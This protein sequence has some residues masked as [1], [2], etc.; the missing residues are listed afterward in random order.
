MLLLPNE[1][2]TSTFLKNFIIIIIII[3]III[4]NNNNN[5]NIF[6]GNIDF[7]NWAHD[8]FSIPRG[9]NAMCLPHR[10]QASGVE[11]VK[12]LLSSVGIPTDWRIRR[13][14]LKPLITRFGLGAGAADRKDHLE[15]EP[16]SIVVDN[17]RHTHEQ[18]QTIYFAFLL[19]LVLA[20][21]FTK[22]PSSS[23]FF[24][25]LS[26]D[27]NMIGVGVNRYHTL[28]PVSWGKWVNCSNPDNLIFKNGMEL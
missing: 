24:Y 10:K 26:E 19:A 9:Q 7:L 21:S 3:I 22:I 23:F 4:N 14:A 6:S 12:K 11:W 28:I 1:L 25:V 2:G 16:L 15:Y 18:R 5:S 13:W 20:I 27:K 17:R 8:L